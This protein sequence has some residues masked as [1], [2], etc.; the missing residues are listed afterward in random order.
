[1]VKKDSLSPWSMAKGGGQE[2]VVVAAALEGA[3]ARGVQ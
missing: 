3:A 2:R 1:M